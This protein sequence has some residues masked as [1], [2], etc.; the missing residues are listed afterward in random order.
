MNRWLETLYALKNQKQECVLVTVTEVEG[1]APREKGAKM[2]VLKSLQILGTIGGGQLE[3]LAIEDAKKIFQS[4]TSI[5]KFVYPLSSIAKQCCGGR[6]TVLMEYVGLSAEIL[7]FGAGHVG[8]ALVQV[9]DGGD[10]DLT[11]VDSREE[12]IGAEAIPKSAQR[13]KEDGVQ[14]LKNHPTSQENTY[15]IVI[16]HSH[17]TDFQIICEALK[18]PSRF[19]GLIGS[20]TK[21]SR[22]SKQLKNFGFTP[23]DLAR[24]HCPV[25]IN[26]GGKS[27]KEVAISIAAQVTQI[28]NKPILKTIKSEVQECHL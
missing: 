21:W 12:W 24:V 13:I 18:K 10:F 9:L 23:T 11:L 5:E 15:V 28:K 1:S 16:T 19:I 8:Q 2:I 4:K 27:P 7:V 17:E 20:E 14:Y 6:V 3:W 26:I 22:F 25:G